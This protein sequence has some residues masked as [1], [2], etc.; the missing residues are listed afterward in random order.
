[1]DDI[2]WFV[3]LL[4]ILVIA[5]IGGKSRAVRESAPIATSTPKAQVVQSV[6]A[7]PAV[8]VQPS[9]QKAPVNAPAGTVISNTVV[10]DAS[11][12]EVSPL[13]GKVTIASLT[14][15]ASP[16]QES[17]L[18]QAS[19]RNSEAVNITGMSVRSGVSL[20]SQTIGTGWP[21]FFP[22]TIGGSERIFLRPGGHAY[23]ISGPFPFGTELSRQGGFQL[24]RCTGYFAQGKQFSPTLPKE[25]PSPQSD[26]LPEPPNSLSKTCYDYLKTIPRCTVPSSKVPTAL[27][28]DGN[29]Q[30]HLFT[31]IN[32]YQCVV[33]YKNAANF[34]KGEWRV[35]LGRDST[36]WR[37]KDEIV[38]LLDDEGRLID[39]KKY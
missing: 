23:L 17:V 37:D 25:C 4:L 33:D 12:A 14:R 26:P 7:P 15:G 35:Y 9:A 28:S 6:K 8:K 32:Y 3:A 18:I 20:N 19:G 22:N 1:M 36:L 21:L 13:R 27:V 5:W 30:A 16:D 10:P 24:N 11:L 38:E 39:S 29:C 31:R 34:Y 2:K